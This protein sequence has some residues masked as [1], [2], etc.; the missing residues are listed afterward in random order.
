MCYGVIFFVVVI[1]DEVIELRMY[2]VDVKL[3]VLGV[4]L[5]E[6]IEKVI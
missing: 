6:D 3:L 4:V 5:I 1:F 2:G